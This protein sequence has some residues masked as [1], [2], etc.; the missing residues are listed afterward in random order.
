MS[1]CCEPLDHL[2]MLLQNPAPGML[3]DLQIPG[4]NVFDVCNSKLAGFLL[5][6]LATHFPDLLARFAS[7]DS[8]AAWFSGVVLKL[9]ASLVCQLHVRFGAMFQTW[10]FPLAS[11]GDVR[12][13]GDAQEA[14]LDKLWSEPSCCLDPFFGGRLQALA[15]GKFSRA[16]LGSAVVQR[17]LSTWARHTDIANMCLERLL[18]KCKRSCPEKHPH[19]ER[20]AAAS[21]L[22]EV[23]SAH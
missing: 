23:L 1:W 3:A 4:R 19:V 5:D 11:I 12:V 7:T 18:A 15:R 22:S 14:V 16:W 9:V 10:P 6:P 13:P 20:M 21:Y 2:W 8:A 17:G